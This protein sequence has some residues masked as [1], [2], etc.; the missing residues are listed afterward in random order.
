MS[1]AGWQQLQLSLCQSVT[2]KASGYWWQQQQS[3]ALRITFGGT[4][5]TMP[6]SPWGRSWT[7]QVEPKTW[8]LPG[9][10]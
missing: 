7:A 6:A 1:A 10:D 2:A 3:S 5:I 8:V 4:L 9:S